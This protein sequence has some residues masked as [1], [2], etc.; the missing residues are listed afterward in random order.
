[1]LSD[2]ALPI[3]G[4]V[5]KSFTYPLG[6]MLD[7]LLVDLL[8][9]QFLALSSARTGLAIRQA[10]DLSCRQSRFLNENSLTFISV[11]CPTPLEHNGGEC[12]VFARAPGERRIPRRQEDEMLEI[13][14]G[15]A[16]RSTFFGE[17]NPG[18]VAKFLAALAACGFASRDEYLQLLFLLH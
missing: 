13:G 7:I 10:L 15:E 6:E 2:S 4:A 5:R 16:K 1:M 3:G 11:S 12:G 8:A 9:P 18:T 14:T 17:H